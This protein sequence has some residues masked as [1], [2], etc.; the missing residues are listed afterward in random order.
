VTSQQLIGFELDNVGY[1]VRQVLEGFKPEYYE[2]RAWAS[3][4][5]PRETLNHLA[6]AYQAFITTSEGGKHN[7]GTFNL[8]GSTWD[9][10]LAEWSDLRNRACEIATSSNDGE[11]HKHAF[12]Y[13][14]A[15][16]SYHVGQLAACRIEIDP[17]WDPFSIYQFA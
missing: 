10:R 12:E 9:E 4:I 13:I 5:S 8:K 15:H 6:E 17:S 7:W 3:A 1:Q 2:H 16:D 14:V 11:V